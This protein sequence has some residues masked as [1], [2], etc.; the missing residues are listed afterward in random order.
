MNMRALLLT[1]L[2]TGLAMQ[3]QPPAPASVQHEFRISNFKTES[4]VTL[5]EALVVLR[6][7]RPTERRQGQRGS[8]AIALYGELPRLRVA[9]RTGTGWPRARPNEIVPC[10]DGAFRKRPVLRVME[11][12]FAPELQTQ[13]DQSRLAVVTTS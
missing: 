6:N 2:L 5:P 12:H 11:V 3:A 8:L 7:L 13:I 4:G 1:V 9:H 10:L